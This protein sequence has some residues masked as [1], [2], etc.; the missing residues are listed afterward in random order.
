[1]TIKRLIYIR[2]R[3]IGEDVAVTSAVTSACYVLVFIY[4]L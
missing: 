2:P 3:V 1:M 4:F